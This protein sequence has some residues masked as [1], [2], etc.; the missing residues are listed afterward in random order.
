M[1]NSSVKVAGDNT[2]LLL[3]VVCCQKFE[4]APH[5]VQ[6]ETVNAAP[7]KLTVLAVV[8][9]ILPVCE[10]VNRGRPLDEAVKRSPIPELSTTSPANDVCP[11]NDAI[12]IVPL[13]VLVPLVPR[14]SKIPRG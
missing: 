1:D 8:S 5:P 2:W 13:M 10:I 12:G 7:L 3:L 11:D 6:E 9:L 14:T 4:P